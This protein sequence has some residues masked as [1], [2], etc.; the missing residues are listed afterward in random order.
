MRFCRNSASCWDKYS[1]EVSR[2]ELKSRTKT[3]VHITESSSH[4]GVGGTRCG[5]VLLRSRSAYWIGGFQE[6]CRKTAG[7]NNRHRTRTRSKLT[8]SVTHNSPP[9]VKSQSCEP[10]GQL[11][12]AKIFK[13]K[14][15]EVGQREAEWLQPTH[16]RKRTSS[17]P[18]IHLC[19]NKEDSRVQ[20]AQ[21]KD[22]DQNLK[23]QVSEAASVPL[24]PPTRALR[25]SL[26]PLWSLC[27][28]QTSPPSAPGSSESLCRLCSWSL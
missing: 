1:W 4:D 20:Q 7:T 27:T 28:G 15:L 24:H 13:I 14:A 8:A 10:A 18:Y 19:K 25:A 3:V 2:T 5:C 9:P 11:W 22:P 12:L 23:L 26:H 16:R 6:T 17:R 21:S